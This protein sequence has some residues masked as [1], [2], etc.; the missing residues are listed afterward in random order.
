MALDG[1]SQEAIEKVALDKSDGSEV[2]LVAL[3]LLRNRNPELVKKLVLDP[4]ENRTIRERAGLFLGV[5]PPDLEDM[6][7]IESPEVPAA[8]GPDPVDAGPDIES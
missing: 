2:R 7:G 1:A 3:G 8:T 5:Y 6:D 4:D